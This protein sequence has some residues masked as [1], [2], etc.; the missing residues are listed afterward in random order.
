[1]VVHPC[2]V[3]HSCDVRSFVTIAILNVSDVLF[4]ASVDICRFLQ[5]NLRKERK[6][7]GGLSGRNKPNASLMYPYFSDAFHPVRVAFKAGNSKYLKGVVRRGIN[8]IEAANPYPKFPAY[9]SN[10]KL[11]LKADNGKYLSRIYR[12]GINKIEAAKDV[13]DALSQFTV[14]NQADGTVVKQAINGKYMG[15][16]RRGNG[17]FYTRDA[18]PVWTSFGKNFVIRPVIRL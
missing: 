15:R 14:H 4:F 6:W 18:L 8:Y 17:R 11:L 16:I 13:P 10:G 3:G 5:C 7:P 1:M 2:M 9:E 12:G